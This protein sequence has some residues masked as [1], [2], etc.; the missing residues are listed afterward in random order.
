MKKIMNVIT[1]IMLV[2]LLAFNI[3]N[4]AKLRALENGEFSAEVNDVAQEDDV[5][6][7][8]G[9]V[10]KSTAHISDAYI[11]GDESG[12]SDADRETLDMAQAVLEEIVSDGMSDFEKERAVYDWMCKSLT[13][14]EG[15]LTVIP[16]SDANGAEPYGVLKNRCGVCVGYATTLRLFM[17]MLG[18]ECMVVHD[19]YLSHSW[20]LVKLDGEW[21][22]TDVY[23]DVGT[24]NYMNFNLNDAT[25]E[26]MQSWNTDFFPEATGYKHSYVYM[27]RRSVEDAYAIPAAVREAIDE[28]KPAIGL[29]FAD[30]DRAYELADTVLDR[31]QTCL[32]EDAESVWLNWSW[33]NISDTQSVLYISFLT[34]DGTDEPQE[35]ITNA[36]SAKID[37]AIAEAFAKG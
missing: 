20:N 37:A 33:I 13:F 31:I 14:D 10:I 24:G 4:Y 11:S 28:N 25:M 19:S 6:I 21:Y 8:E 12:L 15:S 16:G 23:S 36:E 9:Y 3:F 35:S 26:N 5:E 34:D 18:I 30:P 32:I 27:T 22:H 1:P 29:E 17:Q 7:G 2:L